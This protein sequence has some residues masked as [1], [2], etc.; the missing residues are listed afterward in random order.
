VTNTFRQIGIALGTA[1]IGAV[2][3]SSILLRM[4]TA[5]EQNAAIPPQAKSG[6]AKL[7]VANSAELVFGDNGTFDALPPAARNEMAALRRASTTA[8]IHRAFL[9]CAGFALAALGVSLFLPMR[10]EE[11]AEAR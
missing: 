6:I 1:I 8:G 3:I 11:P 9:W 4:E 10:P 5:V 7:L 2:L